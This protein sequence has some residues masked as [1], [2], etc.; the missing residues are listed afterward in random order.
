[1]AA[2]GGEGADPAAHPP[3]PDARVPDRRQDGVRRTMT[4]ERRKPRAFRLDDPKV[5]VA[6][7]DAEAPPHPRG[8]VVVTPEPDIAAEAVA[9]LRPVPR[10]SRWGALFW[11]A[12]GGLVS[13]AVGLSVTKLIDDLFSY[14]D[15]LGWLGAALAAL[16]A[17]AFLAIAMRE[18][19]GLMRLARIEGLHDRAV[20]A[21]AGDDRDLA[22]AL[23]GD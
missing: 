18:I 22:R 1:P 7:P 14:A 15:W 4:E 3:R 5:V 13:L 9:E 10:R 19:A 20:A 21:I 8:A 16:A 11:S 17:V 2:G 12:V 6:D 23:V